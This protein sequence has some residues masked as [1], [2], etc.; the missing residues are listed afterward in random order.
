MVVS[1][2]G[3]GFRN[4]LGINCSNSSV[5]IFSGVCGLVFAA[6]LNLVNLY[7]SANIRNP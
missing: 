3:W 4:W 1:V 6:T 5:C 7:V 2:M